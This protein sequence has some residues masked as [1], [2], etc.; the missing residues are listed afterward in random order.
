MCDPSLWAFDAKDGKEFRLL[1]KWAPKNSVLRV[2]TSI[3]D[4][5]VE[6]CKCGGDTPVYR[7]VIADCELTVHGSKVP[8]DA[9]LYLCREG[10][11]IVGEH[12][13]TSPPTIGGVC[14]V[15]EKWVRKTKRAKRERRPVQRKTQRSAARKRPRNL[16]TRWT[17]PR[18]AK[19]ASALP[20]IELSAASESEEE[21]QTP[22]SSPCAPQVVCGANT[23]ATC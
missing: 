1:L 12:G 13:T 8:A 21:E 22:A 11:V 10:F 19:R 3:L 15:D 9:P 7:A 2:R 16:P 18:A 23:T 5:C 20:D 17:P 4:A 6:G 14:A